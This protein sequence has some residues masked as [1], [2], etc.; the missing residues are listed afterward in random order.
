MVIDFD[1]NFRETGG[2]ATLAGRLLWH[3]TSQKVEIWKVPCP[4]YARP[5]AAMTPCIRQSG[6]QRELLYVYIMKYCRLRTRDPP[7]GRSSPR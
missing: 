6:S 4:R 3:I 7:F 1:Q 5:A 2:H